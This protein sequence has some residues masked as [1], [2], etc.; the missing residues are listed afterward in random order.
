MGRMQTAYAPFVFGAGSFVVQGN[1]LPDGG[2]YPYSDLAHMRTSRTR[3][4]RYVVEGGVA[5]HGTVE[6]SGAKNAALAAMCA[7][8]LTDEE[9]V[10]SN[11][12]QISDAD[13]LAELIASLGA[14]AARR[15]D[16]CFVVSGAGVHTLDGTMS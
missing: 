5:L 13:S 8:L 16:G 15:T 10:L 3:G 9:V 2:A 14:V 11:V 7:G 1:R 4:P 12:P 6:V